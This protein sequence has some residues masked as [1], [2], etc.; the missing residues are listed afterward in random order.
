[1]SS[2]PVCLLAGLL[3]S[4]VPTHGAL[5]QALSDPTRPPNTSGVTGA[6]GEGDAPTTVLQSVLISPGR[7]LAVINGAVVPLGG[8]VGEATLAAISESAVVLKYSDRTEVIKLLGGIERIPV[9]GTR[10]KR[11]R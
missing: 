11:S 5:G 3:A 10:E 2:L 4:S 7:K 8:R 1:M 6:Q 9:T